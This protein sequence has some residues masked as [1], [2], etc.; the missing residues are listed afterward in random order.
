MPPLSAGVSDSLRAGECGT[1]T[2]VIVAHQDG[3]IVSAELPPP[4]TDDPL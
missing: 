1:C 2:A 4:P 3:T